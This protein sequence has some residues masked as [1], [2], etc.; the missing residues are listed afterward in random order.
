MPLY[1]SSTPLP[2]PIFSH[3]ASHTVNY[4]PLITH[5]FTHPCGQRPLSYHTILTNTWSVCLLL[6]PSSVGAG[7]AAAAGGGI[8]GD[9]GA[10]PGESQGGAHAWVRLSRLVSCESR[11]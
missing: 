5:A 10:R 9:V 6:H 4:L 2:E 11:V 8:G 3:L 1:I 7:V